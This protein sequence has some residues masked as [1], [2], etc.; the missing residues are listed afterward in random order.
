MGRIVRNKQTTIQRQYRGS[1]HKVESVFTHRIVHLPIFPISLSQTRHAIYKTSLR[2]DVG[3]PTISHG[4][5]EILLTYCYTTSLFDM[6]GTLIDST[7]GVVGAWELFAETY[8]GID[9]QEIL[10]SACNHRLYPLFNS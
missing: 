4:E 7:P 3:G 2:C 8:P 9:V 10:E 6:D 1:L 5:L